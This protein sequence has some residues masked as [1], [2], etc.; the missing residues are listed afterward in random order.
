MRLNTFVPF[1]VRSSYDIG[2]YTISLGKKLTKHPHASKGIALFSLSYLFRPKTSHLS[3]LIAWVTPYSFASNVVL[4]V[5]DFPSSPKEFAI[6][7]VYR[8]ARSLL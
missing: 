6:N 4:S 1:L 3:S 7:L 2:C 5:L 8:C